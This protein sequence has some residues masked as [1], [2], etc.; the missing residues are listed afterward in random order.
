MNKKL[1]YKLTVLSL[2]GV[3]SFSTIAPSVASASELT[4][5][6]KTQIITQTESENF[7]IINDHQIS[8]DGEIYDLYDIA[9]SIRSDI[10]YENENSKV[11][12]I[13]TRNVATVV[14]KKAIKKTIKWMRKNWTKIY[15]KLPKW[16]QK[17]FKF[18]AF[19]SVCDQFIGISD[20]IED[21]LNRTFRE[22]GMPE[23]ANW[24]ITN[25][26]MILL[27]F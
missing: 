23:S 9:D 24:A 25:V 2:V 7:E 11:N 20:S 6:N 13:Q 22:M 12:S 27:P 10:D 14:T 21:F 5:K 16:A 19:F 18:D 8:V 3:L 1:I 26:I 15:N 17:Y 4:E